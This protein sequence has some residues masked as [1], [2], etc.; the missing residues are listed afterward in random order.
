MAKVYMIGTITITNPEG[1]K[2]YAAEAPKTV[3][4]AGGKYL[5]RGGAATLL[6]GKQLGE[7][8]VVVEFPSRAA[9]EG[10]Y[11]SSAYQA[12]LPHRQNNSALPHYRGIGIH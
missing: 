6:E 11:N 12:I 9:A 8:H 5:V 2:P 7:R 10:W 3:A 1:Y 4:A